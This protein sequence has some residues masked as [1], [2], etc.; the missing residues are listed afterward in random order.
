MGELLLK[1]QK[2]EQSVAS[3]KD[4]MAQKVIFALESLYL[5]GNGMHGALQ[6]LMKR[7]TESQPQEMAL[8]FAE[9]EESMRK[10][11]ELF[12]HTKP[13]WVE[14]IRLLEAQMP[15][16]PPAHGDEQSPHLP[17]TPDAVELAR[18]VPQLNK[19]PASDE[20]LA[21]QSPLLVDQQLVAATA[22]D[23]AP[24]APT[25]LSPTVPTIPLSP[26]TPTMPLSPT[27]PSADPVA[28][29]TDDLPIIVVGPCS[30]PIACPSQPASPI[31]GDDQTSTGCKRKANEE[32]DSDIARKKPTSNRKKGPPPPP[33]RKQPSRGRSKA[34]D[35]EPVTE[36][37]LSK[38]DTIMEGIE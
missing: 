25:H 22:S 14:I 34:P 1:L 30:P 28:R 32:V 17:A 33:Q 15:H 37:Q 6:D 7:M 16:A 27:V 5:L 9:S 31:D 38:L 36:G 8:D 10:V 21:P 2:V 13:Q 3:T 19:A 26:I 35:S 4:W 24:A 12:E 23:V 29:P 11:K 18:T 20:P